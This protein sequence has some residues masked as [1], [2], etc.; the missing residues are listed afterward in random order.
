MTSKANVRRFA[1][2]FGTVCMLTLATTLGSAVQPRF[3]PDDPILEE[4]DT[5][6]ASG[7]KPL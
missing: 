6:D 3:L 1:A 7:M 4:R 2:M 5:E